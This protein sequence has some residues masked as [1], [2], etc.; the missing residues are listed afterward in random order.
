MI[1][2]ESLK[3]PSSTQISLVNN[4]FVVT[5]KCKTRIKPTNSSGDKLTCFGSQGIALIL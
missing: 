5:V 1:P 3:R 2:A 4:T